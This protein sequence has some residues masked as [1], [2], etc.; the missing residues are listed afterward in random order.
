MHTMPLR[1][2]RKSVLQVAFA[3]AV[4]LLI[5]LV[6]MQFSEEVNWTSMDFAVAGFLLFGSGM[7]YVLIAR[8]TT[9]LA[10]RAA[11]CIAVAAALMLIWVNLAVGIIGSENNPANLMYAGVV[12]IEVIGIVAARLRPRGMAYALSATAVAQALVAVIAL[13]GGLGATQPPGRL[14]TLVLNGFFVALFAASAWLFRRA[15][16]AQPRISGA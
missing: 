7:A 5:P 16:R 1:S 4:L 3:T 9:R 10:G 15:A 12:V 11:A 2:M 14:S 6:A 8:S 13:A